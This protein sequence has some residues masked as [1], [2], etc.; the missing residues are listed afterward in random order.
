MLGGLWNAALPLQSLQLLLLENVDIAAVGRLWTTETVGRRGP[1]TALSLERV[2]PL[3]SRRLGCRI[4]AG[5]HGSRG[6]EAASLVLLVLTRVIRTHALQR[7]HGKVLIG[8]LCLAQISDTHLQLGDEHRVVLLQR[9]SGVASWQRTTGSTTSSSASS[10]LLW[11]ILHARRLHSRVGAKRSVGTSAIA[12][13]LLLLLLLLLVGQLLLLDTV[14]LLL[15]ELLL[16]LRGETLAGLRELGG[17]AWG[18][19]YFKYLTSLEF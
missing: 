5:S 10:P 8:L 15:A 17:I 18:K 16:L 11:A 1:A 3:Q 19:Q 7:G 13:L 12:D 4:A 2:L 9:S 6:I 14:L